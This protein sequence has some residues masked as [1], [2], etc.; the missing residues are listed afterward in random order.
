M[1]QRSCNE[2]PL[3]TLLEIIFLQCIPIYG[4]LHLSK[5]RESG[6]SCSMHSTNTAITPP[7]P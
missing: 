2:K 7:L 5:K 6:R 1:Q 4:A 3:N